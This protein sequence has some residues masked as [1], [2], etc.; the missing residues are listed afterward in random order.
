MGSF[1]QVIQFS[2]SNIDEIRKLGDEFREKRA[3]EGAGGPVMGLFTEDRDKPGHYL[4]I[5]EFPSYEVAMQNSNNP[6][7]QEFAQRMSELCD[8]PPTFHNLSVID[9]W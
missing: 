4:N 8:G 6:L 7:T 5:V 1:V 9:R 3:A 2:S